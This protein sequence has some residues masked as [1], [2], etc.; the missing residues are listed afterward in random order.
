MDALAIGSFLLGLVLRL[1]IP[2]GITFLLIRWLSELDARWQNEARR[3]ALLLSSGSQVRNSGCWDVR[4]CTAEQKTKC[5]AFARKEIPCWQVFRQKD[6]VLKERC[7][8]C[9]VFKAAPVPFL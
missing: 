7:F 9:S 8:G 2:L 3:D 4:H 6:G 5:P 1:G